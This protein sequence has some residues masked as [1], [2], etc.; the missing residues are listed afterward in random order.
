MRKN[1]GIVIPI[2]EG[3][4]INA[5][6]LEYFGR[7]GNVQFINPLDEIIHKVDLLVLPGG[8]DIDSLRYGQMPSYFS[9]RPNQFAEYF[10]KAVLPRYIDSNIPIFGVCRGFQEIVVTFGGT[11]EQH[12]YLP[13][14]EPRPKCIETLDFTGYKQPSAEIQRW[15]SAFPANK[16]TNGYT[17]NSLHHQGIYP[18]NIA[19]TQIEILAKSQEYGN[20]E[21]ITI[22]N[23]PIIGVAYHPEEFMCIYADKLVQYLLNYVNETKPKQAFFALS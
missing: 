12:L 14:S 1:I 6:Y 17:V 7:F 9:Q 19:D 5:R 15:T 16:K 2:N 8:A 3:A 23:K 13:M 10:A 4:A 21:A 18:G 22:N 11:L 20:I